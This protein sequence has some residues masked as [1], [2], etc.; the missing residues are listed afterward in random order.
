LKTSLANTSIRGGSHDSDSDAT[1][2]ISVS[3]APDV[4]WD[5]DPRVTVSGYHV[6]A[7]N[8]DIAQGYAGWFRTKNANKSK[9]QSVKIVESI[10]KALGNKYAI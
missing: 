10:N 1:P 2:H 9:I 6:Y 8:N 4:T 3:V 5:A 7:K